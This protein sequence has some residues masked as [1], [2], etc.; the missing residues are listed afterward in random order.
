M[1]HEKITGSFVALITPFNNDGSIDFEGFRT[2]LKF[3]HDNGTRAV[4]IMGVDR[5]GFHVVRRRAQ[6]DHFR[7]RENED[8]GREIVLRLH[9]QQYADHHRVSAVCGKRRR[10]RCHSC[11][12]GLHLRR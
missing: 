12:A 5:R 6:E 7:D 3:H 9:R 1:A 10:R 11:R 2:L 8:A 4:L